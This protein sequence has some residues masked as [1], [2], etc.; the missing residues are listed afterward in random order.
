MADAVE[1]AFEAAAGRHRGARA[2]CSSFDMFEATVPAAFRNAAR[3][4]WHGLRW[5]IWRI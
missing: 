3:Q 5:C 4:A 1:K 2:A